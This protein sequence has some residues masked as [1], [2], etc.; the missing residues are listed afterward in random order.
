M[1]S[2]LSILSATLILG[3]AA[4]AQPDLKAAP[5]AANP[6]NRNA[7]NRAAQVDKKALKAAFHERTAKRIELRLER[8]P[9]TLA[10]LGIADD[11][12]QELIAGHFRIVMTARE[13][14]L[15]A[16]LDL[17]RALII[18][19]TSDTQF[20]A[21]IEAQRTTR[22]AY[23]GA[24]QKA[25]DDLDAKIAYRKTPRLEAVLLAIGALDPDGVNNTL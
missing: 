2:L 1:K 14:L 21:A 24:F 4:L 9:K 15:E 13:P 11:K 6:P 20:K 3:T 17:R 23:E 18:K 22:K 10:L 12:T 19:T 7:A 5:K 16:Q 25:L 8:L